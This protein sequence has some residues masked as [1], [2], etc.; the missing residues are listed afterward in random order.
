MK[1]V[2]LHSETQRKPYK[3]PL[4]KDLGKVE[5]LTKGIKGSLE[6]DNLVVNDV[7]DPKAP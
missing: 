6:P 3:T 4:L 2:I 1:R 5:E 7:Q